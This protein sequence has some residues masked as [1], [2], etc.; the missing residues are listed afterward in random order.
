MGFIRIKNLVKNFRADGDASPPAVSIE[1]LIIPL[2]GIVAIVGGSGSGKTTLLNLLGGLEPLDTSSD[3]ERVLDLKLSTEHETRHLHSTRGFQ[4]QFPYEKASYIFQEGYLLK[5]ASI[6]LNLA[7]TRRAAG[8]SSDGPALEALLERAKLN[9]VES[10]HRVKTPADRTV[11]LSGG[12]QQRINI[13]RAL[14][15]EPEL[16]F[17]DELSSSLDPHKADAVLS[18]LKQWVWEG[19]DT[20]GERTRLTRT[21]LWVTHD[22]HLAAKYADALIVLKDGGVAGGL[23]SP[24]EVRSLNDAIS[25]ESIATWVE[26]GP[27]SGLPVACDGDSIDPKLF[28]TEPLLRSNREVSGLSSLRNLGAGVALSLMEAF[29]ERAASRSTIIETVKKVMRPVIGFA[30]WVR[31]VQLAAVLAL[32]MIIIYG[33]QE[34]IA[35]FDAQLNDP[36]LRHVIVQQNSRELQKSSLDEASIRELNDIIRAIK[37]PAGVPALGDDVDSVFGRFTEVLDVYPTGETRIEPGYVPEAVVGVLDRQEPVYQTL[38]VHPLNEADRRCAFDAPTV[39]PDELMP[40]ADRLQVIVTRQYLADYKRMYQRNLCETPWLDFYDYGPEPLKFQVVGFVDSPPADGY[41]RFDILLDVDIWNT[42]YA[43]MNKPVFRS[44]SRA[45]VYFNQS[46]HQGVIDELVTRAFAFDTEIVNKFS[47]LIGTAAQLR[48][49]FVVIAWLT[50]AVAATVASGLIWSYLAQNAKSIAVLRAHNAWF[51]PLFSAIP[52]QVLLTFCYSLFYLAA[53]AFVWN[54]LVITTP[55]SAYLSELTAGAWMADVITWQTVS[56]TL[57]W[58]FGS[59]LVM[60]LVGW[61]CL[62]SWRL[63]HRNLAHELRQAY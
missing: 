20:A 37:T 53:F 9:D 7:I 31:A 15:R 25:A 48:N 41:D 54:F 29:P 56:G 17:A 28:T 61:I 63:C 1:S 62:M 10:L 16:V 44:F 46:N 22:Y 5:Q 11:T 49:T 45:A 47:R 34:V 3:K 39:Q 32:I 58:V 23:K 33:K 26:K 2:G 59:L 8:L 21:I 43:R 51:W 6:A 12:Q 35:Y 57:N 55:L 4:S 36:S 19:A 50:L 24:I 27:P 42:W 30:H 52:F 40:Y 38:A 60:I 18:E 14:G 13:A